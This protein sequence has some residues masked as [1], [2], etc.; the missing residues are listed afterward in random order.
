ML[1]A[2]ETRDIATLMSAL[3][4]AS[5]QIVAARTEEEFVA[6]MAALHKQTEELSEKDLEVLTELV[7]LAQENPQAFDALSF[8]A[9]RA[10]GQGQ[11]PEFLEALQ[12]M[13]DAVAALPED[14]RPP[15][16]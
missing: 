9:G 16:L 15:S 13:D 3:G 6:A 14:R 7:A 10:A 5:L 4:P 11:S 8:A 1:R 2:M 12:V